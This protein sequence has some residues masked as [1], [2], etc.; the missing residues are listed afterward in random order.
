MKYLPLS[1]V[2]FLLLAAPTLANPDPDEDSSTE[3]DPPVEEVEDPEEVEIFIQRILRQPVFGP[4]RQDRPLR[5]SSRP[6]YVVPREQIDVQGSTTV[7]DALRFVPGILSD[8][9]SGGQLGSVS[10]QFM[11]GGNS[12]Q[13]LILLNGRPINDLGSSGGFDLSSFTTNFIERLE[14]LPGGSSTL[15]GSSAVGGTLN[16][17]S[18]SPTEEPE[19]VIGTEVG[20]FGYNQQAIQSRG[21]AGDFGWVIGYNRTFSRN[22]FPF[23]LGTVDVS[24]TRDNAEAN[25]NNINLTL[26][27]NLGDRNRLTFTGLYLSRD[28]GVP[29]GVPTKPGSTG[30]FNRL[31]P[32]ARQYTEDWLLDLLWES[33]LNPEN[34]SNLTARIYSDILDSTFRDP[35]ASRSNLDRNSFGL[36]VQHNWQLTD[37]QT[38]TYGIDFRTISSE[39]R[40]FNFASGEST[41]NYNSRIDNG[42]AFARYEVDLADNLSLNLG[43]RQEFNSLENGSFTSPA[44]GILWNLSDRT[45]LRANYARSFKSPLISELEGLAAFS[46]A[47]NP[48]LRP[49][50]GHSFDIGLDQQLGDIGLFRVTLFANQISE[51]IAFQFGTPSTNINIG[52]VEALGVEAALDIQ[53]AQNVFAFANLTLN[54]TQ[55]LRDNNPAVEGNRLSFRDADVFNIGVAYATPDGWYAGLFLRNLSNFFTNNTN[56]ERLPGYTTLDLKLQ[57]PIHENLRLNASVNNIFDERYEVFPGFPGLSRSFQAGIR[58]SF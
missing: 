51:L 12:S 3:E 52:K 54:N 46:V 11:R 10:S 29:G 39:N 21:T 27:A 2:F 25:Y 35:E 5:D 48:N 47:P 14:V 37:T 55:I 36:Q 9:T 18:Q 53:L 50:R 57:A 33:Q 23:D 40:T 26:A 6:I 38:L 41:E 20:S 22:D 31:S 42:A 49:E 24:G 7:Q 56:T 58:Y 4:F 44:V 13:T 45:A 16:I 43:L 8:G 32:R 30:E 15:Y 28:I 17:V 19:V 34:T 1:L